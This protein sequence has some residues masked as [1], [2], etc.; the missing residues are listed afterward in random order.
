MSYIYAHPSIDDGLEER[1]YS[2]SEGI[3]D[4]RGRQV[5]YHYSEATSVS[6]CTASGSPF[7]GNMHV[8]GYILRWKYG[9]DEKGQ[10]LSQIEPVMD[11]QERQEIRGLL[12]PGRDGKSRVLFQSEGDGEISSLG[13]L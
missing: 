13:A 5:L 8:R 10:S 1:R 7:V 11:E 2:L 9:T 4:Y 12:W 6:F 3:L